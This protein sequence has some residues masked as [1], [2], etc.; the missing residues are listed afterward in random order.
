MA[1]LLNRLFTIIFLKVAEGANYLSIIMVRTN[2]YLICTHIG[3]WG[4]QMENYL[5]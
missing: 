2:Q 4:Q 1:M 3:Y 5:T